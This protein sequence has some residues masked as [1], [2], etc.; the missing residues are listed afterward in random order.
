LIINQPA[1]TYAYS[2]GAGGAGGNPGTSGFTG[3]AGGGGYIIVD[4]YY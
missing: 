2:V 1:A 4:E 3:G